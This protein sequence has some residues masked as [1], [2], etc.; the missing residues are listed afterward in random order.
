MELISIV[1]DQHLMMEAETVSETFD[2][3]SILTRLIAREDFIALP[4]IC[5]LTSEL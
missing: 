3:N 4:T 1:D 2:M 5:V